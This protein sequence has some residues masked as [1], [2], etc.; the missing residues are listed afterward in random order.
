[1]MGPV[2]QDVQEDDVG[3]DHR[4]RHTA[5]LGRDPLRRR[6]FIRQAF[7][8]LLG[9]AKRLLPAPGLGK[10]FLSRSE[11]LE[12]AFPD[13]LRVESRTFVLTD[14]QA[15]R[16]EALAKA[17][18]DSRLVTVY[19]GVGEEG[20]LGHAFL[21]IHEVRTMAEALLVVLSPRGEVR[22]LRLLAFH[23]PEEYAPSP[24]WL[25]QFE[26]RSL[27]ARLRVGADIHGIA[28]ST[29]TSRAVT[30]AVRRAGALYEVLLRP[31]VAEGG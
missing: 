21:D 5:H 1:M 3:L 11:A 20:V 13:A 30:R 4:R 18:L 29:L 19:T 10:V 31:A 28:G 27:S 16:I 9:L 14:E 12:L 15:E 7:H 2:R 23:E 6:V 8:P 26:S 25:E 24:R 17:P 22:N